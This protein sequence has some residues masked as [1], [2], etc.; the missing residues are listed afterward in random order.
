RTHLKS[1]DLLPAEPFRY[2]PTAPKRVRSSPAYNFV[3][4]EEGYTRMI[5]QYQTV[6]LPRRII[7]FG[8]LLLVL[9]AL[10]IPAAG[11]GSVANQGVGTVRV[12]GDPVDVSQEFLKSEDTYFVGSK[13][14]AFDPTSGKGSLQWQ[15]NQRRTFFSFNKVDR[16]LTPDKG[17]EFPPE[18]D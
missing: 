3:S 8:L 2:N 15:R 7:Y 17:N 12:M 6:L 10:E 9:I 4:F 13:V 5:S 18:Y 1:L 14:T 11:Q 16:T